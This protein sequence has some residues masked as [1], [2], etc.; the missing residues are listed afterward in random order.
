MPPISPNASNYKVEW[1]QTTVPEMFDRLGFAL[2]SCSLAILVFL[3]CLQ[4]DL[5]FFTWDSPALHFMPSSSVLQSVLWPQDGQQLFGAQQLQR[6][7]GHSKGWQE[8]K[9]T[10]PLFLVPSPLTPSP[11]TAT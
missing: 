7:G 11:L 4:R 2:N 6:L 1:D 10:G 5:I 3:H 8:R 9:T